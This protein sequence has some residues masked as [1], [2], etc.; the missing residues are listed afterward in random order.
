MAACLFSNGRSQTNLLK[1]SI[2]LTTYLYTLI[3]FNRVVNKGHYIN[4]IL[5]LYMFS[6]CGSWYIFV[7]ELGIVKSIF[8]LVFAFR[9]IQQIPLPC[10]YESSYTSQTLPL[11]MSFQ[12]HLILMIFSILSCRQNTRLV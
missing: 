4:L 2:M 3:L 5:R 6:S 1:I 8:Q 10:D 11:C 9:S 12:Q 7:R